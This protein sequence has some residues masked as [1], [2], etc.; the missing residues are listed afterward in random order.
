MRSA[1]QETIGGRFA[2]LATLVDEDADLDFMVTHFNK[3]VTDT[4]A[5]L[6]GK[7]CRKWQPWVIP[8]IRAE[9]KSVN[10]RKWKYNCMKTYQIVKDLT[11]EKQ[12]KSAMSGKCLTVE[13]EILNTWTPTVLDRPHI[14]DEEH[15]PI[16]REKVEARSKH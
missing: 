15:Y 4:A 12:S 9:V 14:P 1:F 2:P 8:E 6:L 3:A 11:T 5:K 10:A 13:Q 7:Q 16:L